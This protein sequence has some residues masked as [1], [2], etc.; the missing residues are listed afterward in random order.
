MIASLKQSSTSSVDDLAASMSGI[1]LN[2]TWNVDETDVFD[3]AVDNDENVP[4]TRPRPSNSLAL[5]NS[6]AALKGKA[7]GTVFEIINRIPTV[8][9]LLQVEKSYPH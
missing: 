5:N 7:N 6:S 4:P 1:N 8:F 9:E 2:M 3:D